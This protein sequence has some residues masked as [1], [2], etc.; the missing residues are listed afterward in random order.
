MPSVSV[1]QDDSQNKTTLN[2]TSHQNT[3][4]II[5][6]DNSQLTNNN[7]NDKDNQQPIVLVEEIVPNNEQINATMPMIIKTE[8]SEQ[9]T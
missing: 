8:A 4:Q 6:N 3:E 7:D 2:D 9:K 5:N 1:E